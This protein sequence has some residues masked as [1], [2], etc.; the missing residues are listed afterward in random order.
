[1]G[2]TSLLQRTLL[3]TCKMWS[4]RLRNSFQRQ[5]SYVDS[6]RREISHNAGTKVLLSRTYI[7]LKTLRARKL[8]LRWIS[9]FRMRAK[10]GVVEYRI[11]L[12]NMLIFHNVFQV[13]QVSE[14]LYSKW[15]H[16]SP[17]ILKMMIYLIKWSVFYH[18]R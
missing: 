13:S 8:R 2:S 3:C 11:E 9:P 17:P 10:V 5:A 4:L 15:H 14:T 12:P 1:M 18:M 6:K 7:W 16:P